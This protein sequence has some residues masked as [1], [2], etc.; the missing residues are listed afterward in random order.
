MAVLSHEGT[1]PIM[2]GSW[3]LPIG[4]EHR[5]GYIARPDAAGRFPVVLVLPSLNG[6]SSF[7]KDMCR[8]LARS[9]IVAISPEFYRHEVSSL[10]AYNSLDDARAITDI[11]ELH[12]FIISS[13]VDW[14]VS[15]DIGVLGTDVGGRFGI[16]TA[17]TRPWVKSLVVAYTPLT[18]DEERHFQVAKYLDH[19]PV[20]V[21][22]LYGRDDTLID[23]ST[24][25]EA[26]RRN[27]HGQW[28]LYQ[29]AGHDFLDIESEGFD[30]A[31]A[32]DATAR[33]LAFFSATLPPAEEEDLG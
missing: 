24:V 6:L 9:G 30:S 5:S 28:L 29:D 19:L 23:N 20:P 16:I 17:G 15:A 27:S 14:N 31:A 22:G 33:I 4:S 32:A 11:D 25:D 2:Y 7:E 21:L 3:P 26:Q 10:Q 12:D 13:D 18:G 1:H 8:T